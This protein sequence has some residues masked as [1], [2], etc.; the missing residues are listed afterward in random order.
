MKEA[1]RLRKQAI[2]YGERPLHEQM[3]RGVPNGALRPVQQGSTI[4]L[5]GRG[6]TQG[7]QSSTTVPYSEQQWADQGTTGSP[8][9]PDMSIGGSGIG[10]KSPARR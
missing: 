5:G 3:M 1:E 4:S 8:G 10:K 6:L 2:Q 7:S 9:P